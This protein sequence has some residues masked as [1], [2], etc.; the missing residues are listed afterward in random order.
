MSLH[1]L[2]NANGLKMVVSSRG[3]IVMEIHTPDR[4]GNFADIA[5]GFD[6]IEE[7]DEKSPYFGAIIGRVGNR[8]DKGR[9]SVG[10]VD[11]QLYQ[12]D[13]ENAL[14][15]G[16]V[17]FDK[18]EWT[19][20]EISGEGFVGL[21]LG[22]LSPDGEEGFPGNLDTTVIYKLTDDNEWVIEYEATTDRPTIVNLTQ[23]SYFNLGGH[24]SGDHLDHE[25][26]IASK[27]ITPV[28]DNL[29]PTGEVRPTTGTPFDFSEAKAIG[30]EIDSDDVQLKLAGGYDHNFVIDKL[31][32]SLAN[33]AWVKDSKT[34]R[35][36]S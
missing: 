16:K 34:G 5:L 20:E 6:T 10:D 33:A 31:P 2:E 32:E 35:T 26:K 19:V 17:G 28:N 23:H 14:H 1:S 7:Y 27:F 36:L 12:N 13:G 29:I 8:L 9:F 24:D 11:C 30:E 15:G 21:K 4:D 3:G 25:I 18:V 22:Y